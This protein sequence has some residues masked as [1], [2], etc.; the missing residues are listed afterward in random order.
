MK[1]I[2]RLPNRAGLF[3]VLAFLVICPLMGGAQT[4]TVTGVVLDGS[5]EKPVAGASVLVKGTTT[6]TLTNAEGQFSVSVP[7]NALL[8]ISAIG[9]QETEVRA[10][11]ALNR[12]LLSAA[13][14]ELDQVVVVG[15]GKQKKA[16]LTGA[17]ETI[18]GK[19]FESRAVTNVGLAL[20]GQTPGLLVT[21]SSPRPGNEGIAFTIRGATSVNGSDPLIVVDGVPIMNYYSFQ[22]MNPD[23]IESIS[24]LKDGASAIYGSRASNGVILVTTKRGKGKVKVDYSGNFRFTTNGIT[25]YS[26]S[27]QQY[28]RTWIEANKEETTPNWWVWGEDNV[29]KMEQGVEG[30]YDLFGTDFYIYNSDRIAEM[31]ARRFSYQHN[32]SLSGGNEKSGYRLSLGYA[33][34]QGNLATAYD[35]QKQYNLRFNHDYKLSEKLKI[36]T[37]I[38]LINAATRTP[39]VGLDNTL[40]AFDMPFYPAK[41]PLGQW[42]ATFNGID[43]GAIRNAAAMTSDGG[44]DNKNSLTGRIDVKATY[45]IM[46]DLAIEGAASLQNERFNE[47]KYVLPVQLYNWYGTPTGIGL[48][49][50]G[51]NNVYY[52]YAWQGYYQYYS[53]LLRYNK[54]FKGLHNVAAMAG[55]NAEKN[56]TQWISGNR[57]G[58]DDLGIYDISAASTTTQTNNGSKSLNGRYSYIGRFNYNYGEKYL[59]ELTG[60]SD[61]NS[62]FAKGYKFKNFGSA[63][64]GW[65]FTKEDFWQDLSRVISFGKIRA[66]YGVLGNEAS[67]LGAFDYLSTVNIGT[68][69]IGQPA[70][71]QQSTTLNNSGLISYTRTWERVKTQNIGIDLNF[72]QNRLTTNFDYFTKDNIGM[73]I[74]VTYPSVLGGSAPK[75]NSGRFNTRGWEAVMAWKDHV[76]DFS[77]NISVNMANTRT[78]VTGVENAD[79]Y[80]AGVNN[81]VNGYPWKPWFV[82]ATAGYFKNQEEV[83][84]Y[85]KQFGKSNDLTDKPQSNKAVALRP[86][87]VIKADVAGTGNITSKGNEKS[88]LI[89]VGDGTPH[90]T[91]G[92]N[93]GAS[94]KGIDFNAF[95]QGQLKQ[96]IM[97]NGYMAYPFAAL[98]TNQNPKFLGNT[99]TEEHQDALYPRLTVNPTRAAW[100]YANND[101]MLQNNRYIRLKALILGYTLPQPLTRKVKLDRVRLYFSGEDLWEAT[102]IK[103]GFDPEMGEASI[104]SGYPFARTW[105]FGLN[106]GF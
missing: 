7:E 58:F 92:A 4:R 101:F 65:V 72:L 37:G 12:L 63:L 97:R 69:I 15:Y 32:L 75:T 43:G 64:L 80:G 106:I 74:G 36:E 70:S 2:K 8:L 22:N 89:Y 103:D 38:S 39:S 66:S 102:S 21:R 1:E 82:Y 13:N 59:L 49:T 94:Y 44:R 5:S 54:T 33:D 81:I 31:F 40:Y 71:Q 24:I 51:T 105:S 83:D 26:P 47:E 62:R 28:A 95:F 60:R 25:G 53:A 48:N 52:A 77:Y 19:A 104:N 56:T 68:T 9:Y 46:K 18:S 76:K 87:D 86:G 11:A 61:G 84:A 50:G 27:M 78:L 16:T 6:G 91:F 34:N 35:G 57:V 85:Y 99:W 79:A 67:G 93:I 10:D 42:F 55:I 14:R 30:R 17:V 100:N 45:Q 90:Y 20:Q 73:L 41:N 23:D 96:N 3:M 98:Y 29:K 88:S